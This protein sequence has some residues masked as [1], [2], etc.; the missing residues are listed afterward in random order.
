MKVKTVSPIQSARGVIPTGRI[1]DISPAMV[2]KLKGKV[3]P[4]T[5]EAPPPV[6]PHPPLRSCSWCGSTD[7]WR[8]SWPHQEIW[9]CR[10][11]HPPVDGAEL[12]PGDA[13]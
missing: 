2:K 10:R 3:E 1:I 6:R 11:C 13:A 8:T 12:L 9:R 7:M 4:V 5:A